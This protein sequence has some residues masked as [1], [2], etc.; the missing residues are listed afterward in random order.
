MPNMMPNDLKPSKIKTIA[1]TN[2]DELRKWFRHARGHLRYHNVNPEEKRGVHW[3]S[4]FLE[5]PLSKWWYSQVA[6]NGDEVGGGL[7]GV[8]E[9]EKSLIK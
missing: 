5:G 9:M 1:T 8:S 7:S 3:V 4:S 6:Q 2:I